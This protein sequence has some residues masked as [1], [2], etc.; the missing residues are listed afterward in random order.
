[1]SFGSAICSD[2]TKRPETFFAFAWFVTRFSEN[3]LA[4]PDFQAE[5]FSIVTFQR[6]VTVLKEAIFVTQISHHHWSKTPASIVD[7][8]SFNLDLGNVVVLSTRLQGRGTW[9][10][11]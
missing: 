4:V 5:K 11:K 3:L 7:E 10:A 8:P 2:V 6:F 1:M 9:R